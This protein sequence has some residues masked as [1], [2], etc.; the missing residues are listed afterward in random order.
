MRGFQMTLEINSLAD[1]GTRINEAHHLAIQHAGKA[2]EHA[3]ACGQMLI[4]AK[5]KVPHGKWL[6]WLR[7]NITFSERSAQGY[8]R[9]AEKVPHQIRN[10]VSDFTSLRGALHALAIP[11]RDRRE[12]IDADLEAWMADKG[13]RPDNPG[14]WSIEDAKACVN[15]IRAFDEIMHRYG[16]CPFERG[17]DED[18]TLC[19]VCTPPSLKL[20]RILSNGRREGF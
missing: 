12:A 2:I 7:E 20:H 6:P 15:H 3:I 9:I 13:N 17:P 5:A 14:D 16:L 8:M 1:L 10:G 18:K 11:R 4:A 19:L